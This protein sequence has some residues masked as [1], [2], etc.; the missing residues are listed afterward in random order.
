MLPWDLQAAACQGDA[1]HPKGAPRGHTEAL[2]PGQRHELCQ[3]RS[4]SQPKK[5]P[6]SPSTS[7]LPGSHSH[8]TIR[9]LTAH[10]KVTSHTLHGPQLSPHRQ[11]EGTRSPHPWRRALSPKVP[12]PLEVP[13]LYPKAPAGVED[14]EPEGWGQQQHL[15]ESWLPLSS[16]RPGA[17]PLPGEHTCTAPVKQAGRTSPSSKP[18]G[19]DKC[20]PEWQ[21]GVPGLALPCSSRDQP[22]WK[23]SPQVDRP[24]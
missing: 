22:G 1:L 8:C 5:L 23:P 10:H 24:D 11:D 2:Q 21:P 16:H 17:T 20:A 15:L 14:S 9:P 13:D 12:V 6:R 3:E 4:W 19:Q 18:Q 7:H